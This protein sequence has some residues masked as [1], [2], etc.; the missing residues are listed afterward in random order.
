VCTRRKGKSE[1]WVNE[2]INLTYVIV[3]TQ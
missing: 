2:I 3:A 1:V